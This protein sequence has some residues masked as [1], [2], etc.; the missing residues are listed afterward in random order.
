[1]SDIIIPREWIILYAF[2]SI[3]NII[4][5]V[6]QPGIKAVNLFFKQN[7]YSNDIASSYRKI[8]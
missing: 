7:I 5:G 8:F 2:K 6:L 4:K 1:M 3:L